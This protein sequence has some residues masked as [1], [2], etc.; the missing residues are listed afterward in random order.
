[1]KQVSDLNVGDL[2]ALGGKGGVGRVV[3]IREMRVQPNSYEVTYTTPADR[4]A[5]AIWRGN[6]LVATVQ[7]N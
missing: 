2:I 6:E 1:M 3:A 7:P 5:Y 4:E